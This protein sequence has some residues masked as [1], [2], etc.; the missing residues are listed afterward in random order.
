MSTLFFKSPAQITIAEMCG[1]LPSMD[2]VF[3]APSSME[4]ENLV[5]AQAELL[6]PQP[7]LGRLIALLF[8]EDWEGPGSSQ[9]TSVGSEHLVLIIFGNHCHHISGRF[10]D[11]VTALH[12]IVFMSRNSLL[13][14]LTYHAL[15]RATT[16]WK[17]LWE[18]VY[19]RDRLNEMR[20]I[21]FTKYG[22]EL[23]WLVRK[24]LEKAQFGDLQSRYMS[25]S[26]T[27]SLK[28]L[29]EFIQQYADR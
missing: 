21:G 6:L 25:T 28:E 5:A 1:D 10:A 27:D 20:L 9:W 24:I 13:L 14:S 26:P 18:Y 19:A 29:H 12:S 4:Y 17:E 22:L 11:N 2:P 7:N 16:R 3:E 8:D 23:W 15:F